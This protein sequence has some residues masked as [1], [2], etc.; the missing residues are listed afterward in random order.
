MWGVEEV[1]RS[2]GMLATDIGAASLM[3]E[4]AAL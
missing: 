1:E 4:I 3:A 2:T